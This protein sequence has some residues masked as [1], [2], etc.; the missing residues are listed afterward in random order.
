MKAAVV[1][2]ARFQSTRF[3]GKPLAKIA[4][5]TMIQHVYERASASRGI[6]GVIVATDDE[7]IVQAVEV[8]GGRVCM[9]S[10]THRSGTERVAEIGRN[11]EVDVVVNLQGD[12][13]MMDPGCIE[14]IIEPF[15]SDPTLMISTLKCCAEAEEIS[16]PNVV[17]VVT[18]RHGDALY[19]S[20]STIPHLRR[21]RL[22][23]GKPAAVFK[24]VGI[25]AYRRAFLEILPD[26]PDC[27]LEDVEDLEQLRFLYNGYRIRVVAYEYRGVAVDTPEDLVRINE[28]AAQGKLPGGRVD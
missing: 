14:A 6:A 7:R 1:I 19:F 2:P 21:Q 16:D 20:R 24:H 28:L 22:G 8:F 11:L 23:S 13:P 12:E 18:D 9:T 4:N 5:K 15:R 27:R 26:L 25:Y 17:K 3:P 10:A